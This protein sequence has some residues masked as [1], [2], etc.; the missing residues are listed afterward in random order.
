MWPSIKEP[1][2][3]D[4]SIHRITNSVLLEQSSTN[5]GHFTDEEKLHCTS[6]MYTIQEQE[7]R[8]SPAMRL[9]IQDTS[10]LQGGAENYKSLKSPQL[11]T[12]PSQTPDRLLTN[13]SSDS[14]G[15]KSVPI[16]LK[17][18][19]A[20]DTAPLLSASDKYLP[21]SPSELSSKQNSSC[22]KPQTNF[23][24]LPLSVESVPNPNVKTSQMQV[25]PSPTNA[26]PLGNSSSGLSSSSSTVAPSNA[27][28]FKLMHSVVQDAME[29]FTDQIH[30]NF[31]CMQ[32]NILHMFQRQ[33]AELRYDLNQQLSIVNEL[34]AENRQLKQENKQLRKNY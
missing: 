2:I 32:M 30:N 18:L 8:K 4:M 17:T 16:S 19:H 1:G 7:V 9:N 23:E 21:K 25:Y 33:Q 27:F 14:S 15:Q 29:E 26:N 10:L 11:P 24:K 28:S 12:P 31:L 13:N 20:Q 5:Y 22:S 6:N 3:L 34:V